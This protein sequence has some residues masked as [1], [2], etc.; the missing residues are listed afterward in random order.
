M[1]P[2]LRKLLGIVMIV[3]GLILMP[4]PILPGIPLV[5]AGAAVLGNDHPLV[6]RW[7]AWLRKRVQKQ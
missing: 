7:V 5:L 3:A 2:G 4:V 1:T 6:R